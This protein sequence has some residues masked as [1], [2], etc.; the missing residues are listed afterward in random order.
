MGKLE[1]KIAVVTGGSRDI[2][3]AIS[4]KLAKGGARVV[5]NYYNSE[6]GANE[7]VGEIK[8]IGGH[9]VA[10]KADVSNLDDITALKAKV[11]EAYGDKIDILVNNAGGLFARKTLQEF[12]ETFYNLIMDVNFKSTVFVSQAFEPLMGKGASIINL[13]SQAARDGGGGGSALYSS[14][15]G[16]VST[17]TRAMAK[18][19][20]PKGIRV[21]ALCPG[22]IGTKFHD[23]FTK[24][25]VRTKVAAGTPLRREGTAKEVADLV[26]YL[27]SDESSF[28]TGNNIDING[29][30]AF[31]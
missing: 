17:F 24:D 26:A 2:G 5:V 8:S 31:S 29:G 14:S 9:A 22:L 20:G 3:R 28:I 18:E 4:I 7:T 23:D 15:K 25:E 30:L 11:I 16:A 27:A 10:V 21:N 12:D 19:L 13:S 1:G 6:A